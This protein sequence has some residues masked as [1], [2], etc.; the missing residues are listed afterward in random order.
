MGYS[1]R[2]HHGRY[3]EW[4]DWD[5]GKLVGVE[6]YERVA[7]LEKA[8]NLFEEKKDTPELKAARE[9]LHKEFPPDVPPARR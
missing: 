1:A 5:T 4:R 8:R 9:A 7:E 3:T 6:Y 2:T